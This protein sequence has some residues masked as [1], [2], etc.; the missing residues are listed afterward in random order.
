MNKFTPE[1]TLSGAIVTCQ[2][3]LAV[4]VLLFDFQTGAICLA[5]GLL[6][7]VIHLRASPHI[8]AELDQRKPGRPYR[9][10]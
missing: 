2:L 9:N 4:L 7:L 8:K 3:A 1:Y 5:I 10:E 6:A